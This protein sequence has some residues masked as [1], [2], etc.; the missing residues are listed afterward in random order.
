MC[1]LLPVLHWFPQC[2]LPPP[3]R[4]RNR[5][6][7]RSTT[8]TQSSRRRSGRRMLHPQNRQGSL[9]CGEMRVIMLEHRAEK[10]SH[11]APLSLPWQTGL[12]LSLLWPRDSSLAFPSSLSELSPRCFPRTKLTFSLLLRLVP[13]SNQTCRFSP[14]PLPP[15]PPS[16]QTDYG[17][18][19]KKTPP[20][21]PIP[22]IHSKFSG[23]KFCFCSESAFKVCFC[24]EITKTRSQTFIP[25][26]AFA[27]HSTGSTALAYWLSD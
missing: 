4:T 5:T 21:K 11:P 16:S 25:L 20:F 8:T 10:N 14:L 15:L 27:T 3:L 23:L 26:Q 7:T 6:T 24:S 19:S 22:R 12:G 17:L 2:I 13:G 9:T 18:L 1:R